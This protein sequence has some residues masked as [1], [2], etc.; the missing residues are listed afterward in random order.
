MVPFVP[1]VMTKFR[2]APAVRVAAEAKV[3]KLFPP[4]LIDCTVPSPALKV[5]APMFW[6]SPLASL[7]TKFPVPPKVRAGPASAAPVVF[8]VPPTWSVPPLIVVVPL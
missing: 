3:K 4:L 2:V 8:S 7:T 1:L 6:L 5:S